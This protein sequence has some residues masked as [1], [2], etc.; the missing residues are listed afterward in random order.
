MP[1]C[2]H[3][4]QE[5][6]SKND[7]ATEDEKI[8]INEN[9]QQWKQVKTNIRFRLIFIGFVVV[10]LLIIPNFGPYDPPYGPGILTGA[11]IILIVNN[12]ETW[13]RMRKELKR[14]IPLFAED[15]ITI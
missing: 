11:G 12:L 7:N 4:G 1:I 2:P 6:K 15:G 9:I 8:R 14:V 3:C 5:F 13:Y 10:I